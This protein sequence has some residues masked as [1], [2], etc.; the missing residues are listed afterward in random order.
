MGKEFDTSDESKRQAEDANRRAAENTNMNRAAGILGRLSSGRKV[1][2]DSEMS[3]MLEL[4]KATVKWAAC[5]A[6]GS[7][8]AMTFLDNA[9]GVEKIGTLLIT[10]TF[11]TAA[12]FGG[13]KLGQRT[14]QIGKQAQQ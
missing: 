11:S 13:Y 8:A 6:I 3:I 7:I 12:A 5:V 14:Q 1:R 9:A 10:L 4:F 2:V